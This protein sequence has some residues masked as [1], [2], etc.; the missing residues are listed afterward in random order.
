M[1]H[2][3]NI[4]STRRTNKMSNKILYW[5]KTTLL[6]TLPLLTKVIR[7]VNNQ[8]KSMNIRQKFLRN[9][10]LH[11]SSNLCRMILPLKI[12]KVLISIKNIWQLHHFLETVVLQK[13]HKINHWTILRNQLIIRSF[14]KDIKE[15]ISYY[16][17]FLQ[18]SLNTL[19][20][21]KKELIGKE[22]IIKTLLLI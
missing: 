6:E 9:V 1:N 8:F 22:I 18:K 20:K 3:I 19:H 14:Q 10:L 13:F 21:F 15:L 11:Q 2:H 5:I 4:I 12:T 7:S 17:N 16:P